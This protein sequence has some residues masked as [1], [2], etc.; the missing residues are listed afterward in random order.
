MMSER[1]GGKGVSVL[2]MED[3]PGLAR[4]LQKRLEQAGY[5]VDLA[6]D[7]EEGLAM[8][9]AASYD[10][11]LVDQNMPVHDGLGVIRMLAVQG[12]EVPVVMVTGTGSEAIAVEA[13]KLGARDYVVKDAHGGYFELLPTVI[14]RVLDEQRVAIP[15]LLSTLRVT[16]S[17]ATGRDSSS[18]SALERNCWASE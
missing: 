11:L 9:A 5:V 1:K 13:M 6:R 12:S 16:L 15:F 10:V 4:L 17:T 3:D 18:M 14:E 8:S 2:Y 7:G